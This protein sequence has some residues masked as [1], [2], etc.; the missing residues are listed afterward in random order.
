M[1]TNTVIV[2]FN[3]TIAP[4]LLTLCV[5]VCMWNL[6]LISMACNFITWM[7]S[8]ICIYI[9]Q[10]THKWAFKRL[11]WSTFNINCNWYSNVDDESMMFTK[12]KNDVNIFE[13]E[14][15]FTN[16]HKIR[17]RPKV[18]SHFVPCSQSEWTPHTQ[19][20]VLKKWM[21]ASSIA[22]WNYRTF[23]VRN[24]EIHEWFYIIILSSFSIR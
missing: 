17:N 24:W 11:Y 12:T 21:N 16:D 9:T 10:S 22:L 18:L 13:Q 19:S 1:L 7:H 3:I 6:S 15:I 23:W 2:H 8:A 4:C 14:D 20:N 5:C